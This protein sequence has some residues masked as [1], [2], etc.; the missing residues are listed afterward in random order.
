MPDAA[1]TPLTLD[2]ITAC[3]A[4]IDP[5]ILRTPVHVWRGPEIAARLAGEVEVALKLELFQRTGSFKPRGAINVVRG[6]PEDQR[7]RG[8]TAVSAG[9]H[10]IAAA[11]AA[12]A[13]GISAKVVMTASASPV[14]VARAR[15]F[16]AEVVL[17]EDVAKAF[18]I[19]DRIAAEE[20]RTLVHPFE[21]RATAVGTATVALELAEQAGRLDALI[22][23]IGGGGLCAGMASAIKLL[24]P[25]CMVYGVEPE[26][27]DTM[28]RSFAAGEPKRIDKVRTIADSLG[29]PMALPFSFELCRRNVDELV[30]VDDDQLRGAM[31]L[32]FDEMKLAVEPAGAAA[33]A[34]LVGPLKDRFA[35]QRV[36]VIACGA[37]IDIDAF[38]GHVRAAEAG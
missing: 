16:G 38:A 6:L 21:G 30:L 15:A 8:I 18:E 23:P 22:V 32:L 2:E 13:F 11:Y 33:T 36:G 20:G 31:K 26:G 17:A 25:D 14:R 37:N 19:V 27:A 5:W 9:N 24:Q 28:R 7:A 12:Q 3:R 34:A 35:G 29:A 4:A 10:A 1:V